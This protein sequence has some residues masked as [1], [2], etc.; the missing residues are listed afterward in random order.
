[1]VKDLEELEYESQSELPP[2]F[3]GCNLD[4]IQDKHIGELN[5][6]GTGA[7]ARKLCVDRE[8]IFIEV[9]EKID[10]KFTFKFSTNT[11]DFIKCKFCERRGLYEKVM[12]ICGKVHYCSQKC[13]EKDKEHQ[14]TCEEY[15]RRELD[16]QYIEFKVAED[17]TNGIVGLSNL[18]NTCYMNSALQ[19]LSHTE[20][21]MKYFCKLMLFK[22]ELNSKNPFSSKHNEVTIL[23]AKFM[24]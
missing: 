17:P 15:K 12:C 8:C 21:L 9:L 5:S 4:L 20:S 19:C 6:K 14:D 16:P 11:S 1:M 13:L 3:P 22:K 10:S 24:D 23:F 7:N 18:G 2:V